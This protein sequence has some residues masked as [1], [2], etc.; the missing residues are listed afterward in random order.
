MSSIRA[1]KYLLFK[2]NDTVTFL[3]NHPSNQQ[4]GIPIDEE[5]VKRS[6]AQEE[7]QG[8][9]ITRDEDRIRTGVIVEEWV[10]V[11]EGVRCMERK[12]INIPS[13]NW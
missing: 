9:V 5:G 6:P 3:A 2:R 7:L 12:G 4:A 1:S 10:E 13:G 8:K 11:H